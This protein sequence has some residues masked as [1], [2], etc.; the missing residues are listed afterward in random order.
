MYLSDGGYWQWG[1]LGMREGRGI[2]EISTPSCRFC[3]EVKNK[4]LG[5]HGWSVYKGYIAYK[6]LYPRKKSSLHP[7]PVSSLQCGVSCQ[8]Y[9]IRLSLLFSGSVVSDSLWPH[10]LQHARLPV[11]HYLPEVAQT[12]VHW[13][14]DA[15]QPSSTVPFSSC[16]RSFLASG[17][18]PM[19]R[20]FASGGQRI[21][22]LVS[23]S[24]LPM[25]IQGWFP[26]EW[27]GW[28]SLQ[29]KG[30]SKVFSNTMVQKHQ[31][32]GTQLSLWSNSHIH[33]WLLEKP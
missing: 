2:W 1:R 3:Y 6:S 12:H 32:L 16:L 22:A 31:F 20:L 19:S 7:L 5:K 30:L 10:E 33:T 24:V 11:H 25:N 17:S 21:G 14:G 9:K 18:F 28:I 23:A 29:S 13:V 27:T 15:I 4:V 8:L 26:L